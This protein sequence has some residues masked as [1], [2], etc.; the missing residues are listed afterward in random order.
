MTKKCIKMQN[1]RA[2]HAT[3]LFLLIDPIFCGILVAVI[4]VLSYGLSA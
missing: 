1:A 2:G 4:V 3:L